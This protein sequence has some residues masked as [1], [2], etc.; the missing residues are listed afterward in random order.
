M[1]NKFNKLN[2]MNDLDVVELVAF[3]SLVI[4]LASFFYTPIQINRELAKL[5]KRVTN[6]ETKSISNTK[7]ITRETIASE[8][9]KAIKKSIQSLSS[10]IGLLE[11]NYN[12]KRKIK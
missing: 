3:L 11:T 9:L 6:L 12:C 1:L 4:S 8:P 7:I 10:R 2:N 5:D